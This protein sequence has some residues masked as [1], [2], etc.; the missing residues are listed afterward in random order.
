MATQVVKVKQGDLFPPVQ[1]T[2]KDE[3]GAVVNLTGAAVQ[4][5]M[6]KARDPGTV[7]LSLVAGVVVDGVN[8]KIGYNW[9]AAETNYDGVA[10]EAEFRV[11]PQAGN[12][13]RVPTEGYITVLIGDAV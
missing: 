8:G 9:G 7:P 11:T 1:T 2:V 5:S 10:F 6:R 4:F 13:F 12:P 3:T